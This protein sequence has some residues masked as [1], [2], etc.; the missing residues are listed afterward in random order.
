MS[1]PKKPIELIQYEGKSHKTK[2]EIE[3]RRK[4]EIKAPDD[5]I[6]APFFLEEQEQ[7]DEF[8]G[9]A[10]D[11]QQI[12]I[13]SNLDCDTLGQYIKAKADYVKYDKLIKKVEKKCRSVDNQVTYAPIIDRYENIKNRA[14]KQCRECASAL[15]LTIASR[16]KLVVPK[17]EE[18]KI[19]KFEK[20]SKS[21]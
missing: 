14:F 4:A 5:N 15:G 7:I 3:E 1:R 17:V 21:G 10:N 2:A 18:K 11:L 20:F 19:N 6:V 13:F 16:C 12:G 8:Y 9:Y